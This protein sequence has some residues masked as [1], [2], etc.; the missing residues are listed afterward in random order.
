VRI[1]WWTIGLQAI[2]AIVL[3]WLLGRF[4]FKPVAA[5]IADREA[6]AAKVSADA[7]A[8][9]AAAEKDHASAEAM[10][11]AAVAN[12]A[13]Q[14]EAAAE[15]ASSERERLI[16]EARA[17][18]EK[19]RATAKAEIAQQEDE[20]RHRADLRAAKLAVAI[21]E[22]LM[23]RL[24]DDSR[25]EPFLPALADGIDALSPES[26]ADLANHARLRVASPPGAALGKRIAA[27]LAEKL[28]T[29]AAPEIIVDASLIA[30][31]E[32]ESS[33]AAVRNSL[34]AD[35]DRIAVELARDDE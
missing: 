3:I 1:D 9:R 20:A 14:L 34:R 26:R 7:E 15:A 27:L 35:L 8:L 25:V 19:L 10:E 13:A 31:I 22:R 5:I 24:P 21:A 18:A 16:A 28:G 12:R 23:T 4:L 17:D 33:H 11:A 6:V 30:G 2:N 32:L 29:T